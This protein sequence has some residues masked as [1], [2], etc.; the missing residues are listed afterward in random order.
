MS[1][2][3]IIVALSTEGHANTVNVRWICV[4]SWCKLHITEKGKPIHY[5]AVSETLLTKGVGIIG[6]I[7]PL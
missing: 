2:V 4:L 1:H 5:L 7:S 6:T 3:D